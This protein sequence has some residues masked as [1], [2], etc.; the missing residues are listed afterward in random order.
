[1][2]GHSATAPQVVQITL[3]IFVNRPGACGRVRIVLG[4]LH[5]G[6]TKATPDFDTTLNTFQSLSVSCSIL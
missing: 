4:I 5:K 3:Q 2:K 1:M 6:T